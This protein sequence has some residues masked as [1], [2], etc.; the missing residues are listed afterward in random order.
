MTHYSHV[1]VEAKNSLQDFAI[2]IFSQLVSL[3]IPS[4]FLSSEFGVLHSMQCKKFILD[5]DD[6]SEVFSL[7]KDGNLYVNYNKYTTDQYCIELTNLDSIEVSAV[8]IHIC[9]PRKYANLTPLRWFLILCS[10]Q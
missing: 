9:H 10:L 8:V 5:K 4:N 6:T 1:E 3:L 2:T 7:H